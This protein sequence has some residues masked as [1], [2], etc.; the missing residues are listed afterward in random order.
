VRRLSGVVASTLLYKCYKN[1]GEELH[2][3]ATSR[4]C[5]YYWTASDAGGATAQPPIACF[6]QSICKIG[7]LAVGQPDAARQE[8]PGELR[9]LVRLFVQREMA[10]IKDMDLG[11]WNV[12]RVRQ[13]TWHDEGGII[14]SPHD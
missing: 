10:G 8:A 2:R 6:N 9:D 13:R 7:Q 11:A 1:R 12:A 3:N 5:G 14:A 4:E